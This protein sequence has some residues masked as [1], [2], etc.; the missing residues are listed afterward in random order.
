MWG[1][2]SDFIDEMSNLDK[3]MSIIKKVYLEHTEIPANKLNEILKHDLYF[4]AK[5]CKKYKLV[6]EII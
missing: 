4:D 6:D 5:E 3:L 2:Y 1:K